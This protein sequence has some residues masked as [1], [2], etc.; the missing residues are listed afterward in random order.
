MPAGTTATGALTVQATLDAKGEV[1]DARVVS[2]PEE[3]RKAAL[4]SVFEWH[5][6]PGPAQALITIRFAGGSSAVPG[7]GL[8]GGIGG[9]AWVLAQKGEGP[10]ARAA[11][12]RRLPALPTR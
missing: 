5:Y 9:G 12:G 6:Q 7:Q 3:L 11:V 4:T 8:G 10:A 1:S 2:G